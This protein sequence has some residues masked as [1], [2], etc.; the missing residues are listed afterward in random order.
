MKALCE[1]L[2]EI[3]YRVQRMQLLCQ[4]IRIQQVHAICDQRSDES[5]KEFNKE[6]E[7]AEA[8]LSKCV[9]M[10]HTARTHVEAEV[11]RHLLRCKEYQDAAYRLGESLGVESLGLPIDIVAA[12]DRIKELK[13][14]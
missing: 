4:N 11:E 9:G 3:R 13:G 6:A 8:E 5:W 10:E 7:A 12:A 14:N 1:L 2:V